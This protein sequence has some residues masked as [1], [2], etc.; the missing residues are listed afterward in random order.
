MAEAKPD[1]GPAPGE[2]P[3]ET[4]WSA[5][6]VDLYRD[7]IRA[8]LSEGRCTACGASLAAALLVRTNTSVGPE[9]NELGLSDE[10]AA[11]YLALTDD[12]IVECGQCGA[13]NVAHGG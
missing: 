2:A 8:R 5:E 4:Q 13:R 6:A 7:L 9:L 12:L 3:T 10:A 11:H 1:R